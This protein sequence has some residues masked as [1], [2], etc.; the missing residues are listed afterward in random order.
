MVCLAATPAAS[1]SRCRSLPA[2]L[3]SSG[4]HSALPA[5]SPQSSRD[6]SLAIG[7]HRVPS[8]SRTMLRT[9][10]AIGALLAVGG[11]VPAGRPL[12]AQSV[13]QRRAIDAFSDSLETVTD[14]MPRSEEHTP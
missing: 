14:S 8:G 1:E 12:A 5:T 9:V 10:R 13:A 2:G 11:L 7:E 3:C 6:H 4:V